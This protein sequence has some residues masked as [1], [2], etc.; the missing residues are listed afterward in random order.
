MYHDSLLG[1]KDADHQ[2]TGNPCNRQPAR[3]VLAAEQVNAGYDCDQP[4]NEDQE[5]LARRRAFEFGEVVDNSNGAR[6]DEQV[7]KSGYVNRTFV[8]MT[9]AASVFRLALQPALR[10]PPF[11]PSGWC[12]PAKPQASLPPQTS[13]T[14]PASIR[15][16]DQSP[17]L[18]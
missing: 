12:R 10:W 7:A 6:G 15:P 16:Q 11:R 18:A 4:H 14:H 9:R 17:A 13:A 3:P 5:I 8:H 2:V 1:V